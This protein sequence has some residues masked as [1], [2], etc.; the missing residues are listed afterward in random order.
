VTPAQL[1]KSQR[2]LTYAQLMRLPNVFTAMADIFM[3]FWFTHETLSPVGVFLLLLAS[4]SCLYTAGMVL[5]DV[6]DIEQDLRERPERPLPSGRIDSQT[7]ARLGWSLLAIG[8]IVGWCAALLVNR[9]LPG[10]IATVL[11]AFVVLY[12]R[13]LKRTPWGPVGMGICRG[14]NV[15]LGMSASARPLGIVH[16][17][18]AKCLGCYIAGVTWFARREASSSRRADLIC[19]FVIIA[20]AIIL[21]LDFPSLMRPNELVHSIRFMP[22]LMMFVS[23]F[24]LCSLIVLLALPFLIAIIIPVPAAVQTAVTFGIL[25]II[26]LDA[27]VVLP[28]RG[29]WPALTVLSLLI[30]TLI[31]GR[32]AY[33]T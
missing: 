20:A 21:L 14:L 25:S 11:A 26:V 19:G 28:V 27:L 18:V 29:V 5:N 22:R 7:G 13:F 6:F 12:D 31:L 23:A 1:I 8:V 9:M 32:S 16:W 33:S 3:G 15:I 24:F 30:P 4:S 2:L 10:I 17:Y